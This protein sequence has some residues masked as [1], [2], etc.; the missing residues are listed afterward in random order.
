M[1]RLNEFLNDTYFV[2]VSLEVPLGKGHSKI[3]I[4]IITT[5]VLFIFIVIIIA[6]TTNNFFQEGALILKLVSEKF[7]CNR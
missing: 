7:W 6:L 4:T 3:T 1:A 2:P 5:I